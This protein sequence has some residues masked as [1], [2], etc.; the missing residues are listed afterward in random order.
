[1]TL[2]DLMKNITIFI[3]PLAEEGCFIAKIR[4]IT[5]THEYV[6]FDLEVEGCFTEEVLMDTLT[7]EMEEI[8]SC[9]YHYE[10]DQTVDQEVLHYDGG[11]FR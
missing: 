9:K 11:T 2:E 1:M 5:P 6:Y 3:T 7:A 10:V 4:G 8:L